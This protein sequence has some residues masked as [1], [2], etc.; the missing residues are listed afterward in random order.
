MKLSS[1][2]TTVFCSFAI[3]HSACAATRTPQLANDDVTVWQ[4]V[5]PPGGKQKLSMH[6]HEHNRV[7]VPL[8]D[9]ELKV[10]NDRGES[11]MLQLKKNQAVYLAK[12]IPNEMHNDENISHHPIKVLVIELNHA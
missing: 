10:T 6:R 9:G 12:D 3:F 1:L 11:H 2:F 8:T 7:V 4:T 5:I